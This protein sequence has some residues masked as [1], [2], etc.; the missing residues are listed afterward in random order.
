MI[1]TQENIHQYVNRIFL[2]LRSHIKYTIILDAGIFIWVHPGS[3]RIIDPVAYDYP[4][5]MNLLDENGNIETLP[6]QF[7]YKNSKNKDQFDL[8]SNKIFA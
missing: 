1:F 2:S 8:Q 5:N 4:Y 6:R 3:T 7:D